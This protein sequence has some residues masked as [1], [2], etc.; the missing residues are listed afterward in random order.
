MSTGRGYGLL[1]CPHLIPAELQ[2][3]LHAVNAESGE[4]IHLAPA[5][6][7]LSCLRPDGAGLGRRPM[8]AL[9]L[10]PRPSDTDRAEVPPMDEIALT[11]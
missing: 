8:T 3:D 6:A 10:D 4:V 9:L 7:S 1:N 5:A 11:A 2:L